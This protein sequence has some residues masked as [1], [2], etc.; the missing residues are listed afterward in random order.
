MKF[1][2]PD[3]LIGSLLTIAVF[4]VGMIFASGSGEPH[5]HE[6]SLF[7]IKLGEVL[8][9]L[10]TLLLWKATKDLVTEANTSSKKQLR[11]YVFA[12][13]VESIWTADKAT[14]SIIKWT[15]FPVWKN[16]GNTPTKRAISTINSWIGENA[17]ELPTDFDFPDYGTPGRNFVGP[18]SVMHGGRVDLAIEQL[19]K[20]RAGS[21]RAYLWGWIEYDD[22]FPGTERHRSEFCFEIRVTGNPIYKE[23]GFAFP[24]HGPFNGYDEDC[25]LKPRQSK[26]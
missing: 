14:E 21:V 24:L 19:E 16:S 9:V 7:E 10:V 3:V 25:Y 20:I 11:A 15:F 5:A 17:G 2:L 1:R 8:L 26:T 4:S 18:G 13:N 22:V 6:T 12:Q 23:G